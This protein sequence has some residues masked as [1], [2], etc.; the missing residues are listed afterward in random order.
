MLWQIRLYN[1][2]LTSSNGT[3]S[4][5]AD[6]VESTYS[7]PEGVLTTPPIDPVIYGN[8]NALPDGV[9]PKNVVYKSLVLKLLEYSFTPKSLI[10]SA[11]ISLEIP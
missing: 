3:I 7:Y 11:T 4:F 2:L 1:R 6:I 10:A 5:D 9:N 8:G